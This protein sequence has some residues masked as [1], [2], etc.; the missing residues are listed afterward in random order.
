MLAVPPRQVLD[1]LADATRWR[2][3]MPDVRSVEMVASGEGW[4]ISEWTVTDLGQEVRWQQRDEVKLVHMTMRSRQVAGTV[5]HRLDIVLPV[6]GHTDVQLSIRLE[7]ARFPG[8]ILPVVREVI[9]R[10]YDGLIAGIAAALGPAS[11]G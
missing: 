7:V 3:H 11:A 1:V 8:L 9:R 5:L 2:A 6:H 4:R 10:N